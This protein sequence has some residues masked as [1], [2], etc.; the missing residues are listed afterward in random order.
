MKL[1]PL[2]PSISACIPTMQWPLDPASC[3]PLYYEPLDRLADVRSKT[4]EM[5]S[6]ISSIVSDVPSTLST[7]LLF[8]TD[9]EVDVK[10]KETQRASAAVSLALLLLGHGFADEAHDL[11][12]P[13]CWPEP[14]HFGFEPLFYSTSDD[15]VVSAAAYV[16]SLVHRREGL[17]VGEYGMIGFSNANY[18]TRAAMAS[19]GSSSLPWKEVRN[20]VLSIADDMKDDKEVQVW[21]KERVIEEGDDEYW[22]PRAL[23]ELCAQVLQ[24]SA[25]DD[26]NRVG[27]GLRTFAQL[28]AEAEVHVLLRH[29]FQSA[30][31]EYPKNNYFSNVASKEKEDNNAIIPQDNL[32]RPSPQVDET[33]ALTSASKISSAHANAFRTNGSVTL[34]GVVKISGNDDGLDTLSAFSAMAGIA[35]RL[36]NSPACCLVGDNDKSK[37]GQALRILLPITDSSAAALRSDVV[38]GGGS[39]APG[40]AF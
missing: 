33:T 22:E 31:F 2:P 7:L 8:D 37:A 12:T 13:L 29:C 3:P 20:T 19:R 25:K 18:W 23:H 35:A 40:D 17:N 16:H 15:N 6:P 1:A 36:L 5:H 10:V 14:T 28:S 4:Q 26:D 27:S 24:G 32:S 21:T 38:G 39:L 11:V 34:R 9:D 30:G